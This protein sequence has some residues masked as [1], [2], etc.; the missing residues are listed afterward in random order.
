[1]INKEVTIKLKTFVANLA[2]KVLT[3]IAKK[4]VVTG[5]FMGCHRP[6]TPEELLRS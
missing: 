4:F 6:E 1:M 3:S 2:S 5:C